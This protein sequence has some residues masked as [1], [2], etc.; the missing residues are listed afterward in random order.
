MSIKD[1]L[2]V[3]SEKQKNSLEKLVANKDTEISIREYEVFKLKEDKKNLN[4]K[5][6]KQKVLKIGSFSISAASIGYILYHQITKH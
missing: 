5:L 1:S 4:I 3:S 2:L 6:R